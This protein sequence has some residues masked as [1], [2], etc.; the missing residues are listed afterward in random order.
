[1]RSGVI[2]KKMGMTRIFTDEG[3]HIPVTVLKLDGCQVV[4]QRTREKNGYTAVQLGAGFAK[5]K[6]VSK[7]ERGRFAVSKVEPKRKVVEFRVAPG[8]MVA[9]GTEI[10]ADHF[11]EGQYIDATGTSIGKGFAGGMK[12]HGFGGLRASHGVSVSHRSHGSTGQCQD[13]GKVFKGKKMAGHMGSVRVTT[14]NLEVV[15]VDAERDLVMVKGGIPGSRGSWIELR[16]AVKKKLPEAAPRPAG[17]KNS[18]NE[19]A[20][21]TGGDENSEVAE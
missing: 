3:V 16:D 13:P 10:S 7:A 5:V 21:P 2:A 14:Q 11:V 9:V 17:V 15:K 1:M 19:G 4:A 20:A 6:N 18:A 8:N 12:R